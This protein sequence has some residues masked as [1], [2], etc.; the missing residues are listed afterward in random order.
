MLPSDSLTRQ[1]LPASPAGV[2]VGDR[3]GT[4]PFINP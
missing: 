2:V 4:V 1:V 3:H